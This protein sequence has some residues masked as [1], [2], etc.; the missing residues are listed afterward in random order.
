MTE[1]RSLHYHFATEY[2]FRK[3]SNPVGTGGTV[4][5][6]W[7]KQLIGETEQQLV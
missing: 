4:F 1:F 7:L 2:I 6:D 5:M 3:V